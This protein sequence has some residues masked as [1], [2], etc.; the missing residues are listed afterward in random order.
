[1]RV[2]DLK[3]RQSKAYLEKETA[4]ELMSEAAGESSIMTRD[5]NDIDRD[6]IR[7]ASP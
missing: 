1:M 6:R 4:A 2:T 7:P 5:M 3:S